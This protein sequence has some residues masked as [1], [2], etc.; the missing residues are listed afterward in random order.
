MIGDDVRQLGVQLQEIGKKLSWMCKETQKECEAAVSEVVDELSRKLV[1]Y[2]TAL[3]EFQMVLQQK[4]LEVTREYDEFYKRIRGIH[5][6]TKER[7]RQ[8]GELPK[9]KLPYGFEEL[10]RTA[11]RYS[12]LS[13][14]QWAKVGELA[15]ALAATR[16]L[17]WAA[18]EGK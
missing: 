12:H 17:E 8:L 14:E 6:Q 13:D 16:A 10:I 2:E 18:K 15:K 1:K 9:V 11:E 7:I 3:G 4:Q 5:E